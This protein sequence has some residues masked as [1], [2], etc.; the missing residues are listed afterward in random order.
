[1]NTFFR[2]D[3]LLNDTHWY[4]DE[5]VAILLQYYFDYEPQVQLFTDMSAKRWRASHFLRD[6]LVEFNRQR[7]NCIN[8]NCAVKNKVL[9]PIDVD[10]NHWTLL[11][12]IYP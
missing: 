3:H 6:N 11:Y 8:N 1:M 12:I 9:I 10:D 2:R 7:S 5:E 4:K